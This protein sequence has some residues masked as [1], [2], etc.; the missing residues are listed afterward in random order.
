MGWEPAKLARAMDSFAVWVAAGL[1]DDS[2]FGFMA[3]DAGVVVA[4]I[5][6]MLIEWP[7]HPLHPES[8]HRGY[9]LNL[10]VDPGYRRQGLA[11]RLMESAEAEFRRRGVSYAV[12]HASKMGRPVYEGLGWVESP[13]MAKVL[14]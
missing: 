5:G 7:P 11:G 8:S 14:E 13:E 9:I 3:E 1:E 12:L 10:F 2:Y 4:G 6:L